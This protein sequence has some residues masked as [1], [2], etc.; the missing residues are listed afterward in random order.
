MPR[1]FR[2][3]DVGPVAALQVFD[4]VLAI[5][6]EDLGMHARRPVIAHHDLVIRLTADVKRMFPD[7]DNGPAPGGVHYDD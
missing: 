4:P 6:Q 7:R 1:D 5:L 3:V 2:A